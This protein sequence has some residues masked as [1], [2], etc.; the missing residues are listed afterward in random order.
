LETCNMTL[1]DF[2]ATRI[3]TRIGNRH[4]TLLGMSRSNSP[5]VRTVGKAMRMN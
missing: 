1:K 2:D 5:M 3:G 4:Y